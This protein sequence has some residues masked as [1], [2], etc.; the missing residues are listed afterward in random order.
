ML[1]PNEKRDYRLASI[2]HELIESEVKQSGD[3]A[4]APVSLRVWATHD[5]ERQWINCVVRYK[6]HGGAPR[7]AFNSGMPA[8]ELP[9]WAQETLGWVERQA[10]TF[11]VID[12]L[13]A[14]CF[15]GVVQMMAK[16]HHFTA[17][18]SARNTKWK[19]HEDG[20]CGQY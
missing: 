14:E 1:T 9:N 5:G 10:V 2:M 13:D 18:M 16:T 4:T 7:L 8:H 12:M 20:H 6:G 11:F 17:N 19:V 15:D 3:R